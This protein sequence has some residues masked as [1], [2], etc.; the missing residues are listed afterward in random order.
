MRRLHLPL[1]IAALLAVSAVHAQAFT[2]LPENHW[3]RAALENLYG[4]VLAG[5]ED[6]AFRGSQPT[7][8]YEAA[9]ALYRLSLLFT[10][11]LDGHSSL[12]NE[13]ER[14]GKETFVRRAESTNRDYSGALAGLEKRLDSLDLKALRSLI[15]E[16][17]KELSALGVSVDSLQSDVESVEKRI[18]A[19]ESRK[20]IISLKG[21][22]SAG[23]MGAMTK[24]GRLVLTSTGHKL[25]SRDGVTA[26]PFDKNAIVLH[27]ALF[28]VT[29]EAGEGVRFT[30]T[31]GI[32][33]TLRAFRGLNGDA[34]GPLLDAGGDAHIEELNAGWSRR[35]LR[36]SIEATVGRFGQAVPLIFE[37]SINKDLW[38]Q[39]DLAAR[40]FLVD[41]MKARLRWSGTD[42]DIFAGRV[43]GRSAQNNMVL[44]APVIKSFSTLVIPAESVLGAGLDFQA[45]SKVNFSGGMIYVEGANSIGVPPKSVNRMITLGGALEAKLPAGAHI[46]AGLAKN[47][48]KDGSKTTVDNR[49]ESY[50]AT[51]DVPMGSAH[52]ELGYKR[53][54]HNSFLNGDWGRLGAII[55]PTG[56][57]SLGSRLSLRTTF[58]EVAASYEAAEGITKDAD[59]V[60]TAGLSKGDKIT[61]WSVEGDVRLSRSWSLMASYS[62][63]RWSLAKAADP[64][65][66]FFTLA[67]RTADKDAKTSF[68]FG[69][70]AAD[71]DSK[72][73]PF[74]AWQGLDGAYRGTALFSRWTVK[75]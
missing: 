56:Y 30:G 16:F 58:G 60:G 54:E 3:S 29:G 15:T 9:A 36:G 6:G 65:Q 52:A 31:F 13:M 34:Q 7:T 64:R 22:A 24:D 41:G 47:I 12:L 46:K 66:S 28:K 57:T 2:D 67:L 8:R 11:R 44:S 18:A 20:S 39:S 42:L 1:W 23:A 10:T 4:R 75:F 19:L 51:L 38:G 74:M 33:N 48:L 61:S 63:V 43:G 49:N 55:N 14:A 70:Q 21:E 5:R 37:P 50:F 40:G 17:E 69:L 59:K 32:G 45:N 73:A 25:G 62:D 26:T 68:L 53:R 35:M 71:S 27:E 72:G